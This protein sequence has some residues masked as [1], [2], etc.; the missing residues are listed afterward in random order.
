MGRLLSQNG[1]YARSVGLTATA[2]KRLGGAAHLK[3]LEPEERAILLNDARANRTV[4]VLSKRMQMRPRPTPRRGEPTQAE[5]KA[6][7]ELARTRAGGRCQLR[8]SKECIWD[9]VWPLL[10]NLL[11]R[12]HLHHALSKRRFGWHE[13]TVTGQCHLWV[14]PFC[15]NYEHAGR[16]PCPSK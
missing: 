9:K 14:C 3:S 8:I 4:Q 13:S 16:K 1:E 6:A 11:T 7:R 2:I 15:H 5:R 10:G 12:G